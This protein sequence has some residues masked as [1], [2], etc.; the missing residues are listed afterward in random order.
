MQADDAEF[1]ILAYKNS[2]PVLITENQVLL[3]LPLTI[4]MAQFQDDT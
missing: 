3:T 4:Y 2:L 1:F